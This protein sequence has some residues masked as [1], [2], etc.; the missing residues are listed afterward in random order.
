MDNKKPPT[1]FNGPAMIEGLRNLQKNAEVRMEM[2]EHQS[3]MLRARYNMCMDK[4]F[5]DAQSL[6]LCYQDWSHAI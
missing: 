4:G 2:F 5:T 3:T 6:F 1:P